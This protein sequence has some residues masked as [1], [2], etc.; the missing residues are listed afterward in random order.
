MYFSPPVTCSVGAVV[1][2]ADASFV[3]TKLARKNCGLDWLCTAA[4]LTFVTGSSDWLNAAQSS[5]AFDQH[6]AP[7]KKVLLL[8]LQLPP[9]LVDSE[10]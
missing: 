10:S 9:P 2:R 5:A 6:C 3:A 7:L 4:S 1:V 8:L